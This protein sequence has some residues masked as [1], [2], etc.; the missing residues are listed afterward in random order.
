MY[1][2][3]IFI[4]TKTIEAKKEFGFLR[5]KT[6]SNFGSFTLIDGLIENED[7][8]SPFNMMYE[9]LIYLGGC[10]DINITN[11]LDDLMIELVLQ[12][13]KV[14]YLNFNEK[15]HIF[16]SNEWTAIDYSRKSEELAK[17]Y[18]YEEVIVKY[19]PEYENLFTFEMLKSPTML[20]T[21]EAERLYVKFMALVK[22]VTTV[23]SSKAKQIQELTTQNAE[24][25]LKL[26]KTIEEAN[27]YKK[28]CNKHIA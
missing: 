15:V 19:V 12:M 1:G 26:H 16:V 3:S 6:P 2:I 27:Y 28:K 14:R 10:E 22:N 7:Y 17:R 13:I 21:Q 8:I 20:S 24:L 25:N 18:G 23:K 11:R 9:E 5:K 4:R